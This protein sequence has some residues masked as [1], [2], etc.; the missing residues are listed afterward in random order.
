VVTPPIASIRSPLQ[1]AA[2]SSDGKEVI[3]AAVVMLSAAEDEL[4]E[5]GAE[6]L[7]LGRG[8]AGGRS[9]ALTGIA[10]TTITG[11]AGVDGHEDR[12]LVLGVDTAGD[13]AV[14][15]SW[16]T[17]AQPCQDSNISAEQTPERCAR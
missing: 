1:L 9:S 2:A 11:A 5:D 10:V 17:I 7:S 15:P 3:V 13:C 4:N 8:E 14:G 16:P 12:L 6:K